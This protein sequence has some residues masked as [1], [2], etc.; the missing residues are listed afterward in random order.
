MYLE[1]VLLPTRI[2]F[3]NPMVCELETSLSNPNRTLKYHTNLS[4]SKKSSWTFHLRMMWCE[5]FGDERLIA[6]V[7]GYYVWSCLCLLLR[8]LSSRCLVNISSQLIFCIWS[9]YLPS[10][11]PAEREMPMT[12]FFTCLFI[13][14]IENRVGSTWFRGPHINFT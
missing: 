4:N 9:I 7:H 3:N 8:C 1:G 13:S 14:L 2:I 6:I 12:Y 5:Y 11:F 10:F